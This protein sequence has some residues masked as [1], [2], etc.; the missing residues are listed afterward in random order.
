SAIL[1]PIEGIVD[2]ANDDLD[3]SPE[4]INEDCYANH[5]YVLKSFSLEDYEALLG[6]EEYEAY[7]T[8]L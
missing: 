7:L 4:L 2:Q 8:S 1:N 3:G 6:A 5:L